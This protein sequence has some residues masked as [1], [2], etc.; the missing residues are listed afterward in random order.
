MIIIL[1]LQ[2]EDNPEGIEV[3]VMRRIDQLMIKLIMWLNYN[4]P[5][6]FNFTLARY[7]MILVLCSHIDTAVTQAENTHQ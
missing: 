4:A 3:T 6:P 5:A 7:S 1:I 2:D